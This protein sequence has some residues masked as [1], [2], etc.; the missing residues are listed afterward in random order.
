MS[1]L[2][3]I[4]TKL[5]PLGFKAEATVEH[6]KI[7]LCKKKKKKPTQVVD[8]KSESVLYITKPKYYYKNLFYLNLL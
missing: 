7:I 3:Q 1:I 6:R 5:C 4:Q 8:N 2:Q